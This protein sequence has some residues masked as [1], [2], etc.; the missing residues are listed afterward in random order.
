M[1]EKGHTTLVEIIILSWYPTILSNHC[2]SF[3][4]RAPAEKILGNLQIG[5]LVQE[6]CNSSVLAMELRL[7]CTNP[8]KWDAVTWQG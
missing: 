7:S 6:R 1:W 2:N 4:N 5:G 3:K 8:S